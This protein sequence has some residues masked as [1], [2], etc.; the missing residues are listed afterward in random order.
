MKDAEA[1]AQ[2]AGAEEV[3]DE[4]MEHVSGM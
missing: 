1:I 3:H 4:P 2:F